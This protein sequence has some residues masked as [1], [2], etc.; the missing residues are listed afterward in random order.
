MGI[1]IHLDVAYDVSDE[2]WE[3]VYEES[4]RL[5]EKF[6]LMDSSVLDLFGKC[7]YCG[8]PVEEREKN[9]FRF[10]NTIGDCRSMGSAEDHRL[11]RK[12]SD[13]RTE[14]KPGMCCDPLL[15]I[16]LSQEVL[17]WEDERCR[18]SYGFWGNKTQG[19]AYHMYLLAIGCM[20]ESRLNGKACVSGDITLGQCRKAVALANEHVSEPIGLPVRCELEPLYRRICSLPLKGSEPLRLFQRLY[21]GVLNRDYGEFVRMHFSKEEIMTYWQNKFGYFTIGTVGFSSKLKE[22]FNLG[23]ELEDLCRMIALLDVA[24]K[25]DYASFVRDVMRTNLFLEQKDLRD[26]LGIEREDENPYT[27]YTLMAQFAFAGAANYNVDAYMPIEKITEILSV[28]FGKYC[29]VQGVIDEYMEQIEAK[30]E[31]EPSIELNDIMDAVERSVER[32]MESYDI[33]DFRDLLYYETGDKLKPVL[34]EVCIKS[35]EF[36]KLTCEEERFAE[37][38]KKSAEERCAYLIYQNQSLLLMKDRWLRIFDEIK[39]DKDSFRRYYPMVRVQM[40]SNTSWFVYAYVAN[41]DFYHH[42]EEMPIKI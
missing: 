16:N 26:C 8:M 4:L 6:Q 41:D 22:Y 3:P 21:L 39:K 37:L 25:E 18:N 13:R 9:G 35:I 5:A 11:Y 28:N 33:S 10:W 17:G 40:N 27:I 36:Y 38:M 2:E 23:N 29:D 15:S 42:F 14:W 24:G 20:I 1:F 7:L 19:E 32:D 30:K 34:E 31:E 12:L